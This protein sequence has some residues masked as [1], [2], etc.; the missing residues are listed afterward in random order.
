MP[1]S[2]E[3]TPETT[4]INEKKNSKGL[5]ERRQKIS[6]PTMSQGRVSIM[7]PPGKK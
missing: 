2:S 3:T 7:T 5:L 6:T 4:N 1:S